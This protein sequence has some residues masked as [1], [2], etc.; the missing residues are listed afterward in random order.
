MVA[1]MWRRIITTIDLVGA[2]VKAQ[3]FLVVLF[4]V[5]TLSPLYALTSDLLDIAEGATP[6]EIQ[7]AV[8]GGADPN[9]VDST[10][11]TVLMLAAASNPDPAAISALVKAGAKVNARGPQGWT[12]LMM[13][14]YNNPNPEVA[15]ALM[16]AGADPRLRSD[17]GRTAFDYAQDNDTLK[18]S[19]ALEKLRAGGK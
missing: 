15:L 10:G 3:L 12:P 18:G 8:H 13:A 16:A 2:G 4:S 11:R 14:A 9:A 6:A 17:A 19:A 5:L 7:L 1:N